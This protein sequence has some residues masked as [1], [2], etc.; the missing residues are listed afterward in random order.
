[1]VC[2]ACA[3]PSATMK[4]AASATKHLNIAILPV[5]KLRPCVSSLAS[6]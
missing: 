5:V 2:C 4:P 1:L 3:E 6:R